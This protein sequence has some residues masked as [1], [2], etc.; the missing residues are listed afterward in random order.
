MVQLIVVITNFLVL[1]NAGPRCMIEG[2][3]SLGQLNIPA[4]A[5]LTTTT[6]FLK[7]AKT[8]LV[9]T[10]FISPPVFLHLLSLSLIQILGMF[11]TCVPATDT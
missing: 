2:K 3:N 11:K 7:N 9:P 10:R 1:V 6:C 8:L 5:P 4:H